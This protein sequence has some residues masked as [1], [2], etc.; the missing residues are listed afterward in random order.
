MLS[1]FSITLSMLGK[2]FSVRQFEIFSYYPQKLSF[3]I[4]C[5]LHE[6]AVDFFLVK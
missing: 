3:N 2:T 4:I 1:N 5:N 6:M